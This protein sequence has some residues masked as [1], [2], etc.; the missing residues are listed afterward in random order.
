MWAGAPKIAR[1]NSQYNDERGG[2][3]KSAPLPSIMT[4]AISISTNSVISMN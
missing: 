1:M 4:I 3:Q 2:S